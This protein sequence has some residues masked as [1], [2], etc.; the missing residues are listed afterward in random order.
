MED[1]KKTQP[2]DVAFASFVG[3]MEEWKKGMTR[4]FDE[5]RQEFKDQQALIAL[6]LIEIG[7]EKAD[8]KV[9]ETLQK[10]INEN[11]TVRLESAEKLVMLNSKLLGWMILFEVVVFGMVLFHLTGYHL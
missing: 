8:Q 1:G 11:I 3:G 10:I 7:K 5:F 4:S 2:L 6:K 9:V